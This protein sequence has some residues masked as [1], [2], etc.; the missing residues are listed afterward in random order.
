MTDTGRRWDGDKV[1]VRDKLVLQKEE[2]VKLTRGQLPVWGLRGVRR[3]FSDNQSQNPWPSY[4]STHQIIKAVENNNF[5]KKTMITFHPQRWHD[6]WLPW[7][8]ELVWQNTKNVVKR[9]F[10]VNI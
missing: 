8:K 3:Q 4:H 10:F 5:P 7:G 6:R 2:K 9:L 1:S